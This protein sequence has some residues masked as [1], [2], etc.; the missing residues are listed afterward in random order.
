V[1]LS[2]GHLSLRLKLVLALVAV[3]A[4][5][6]AVTGGES[7][8]RARSALEAAAINQLTAIRDERRRAVEAYFA[9][10]RLE[11]VTL[12]ETHLVAEAMRRFASAWDA[13][14][15]EASRLPPPVVAAYRARVEAFYQQRLAPHLHDL[16]G[17]P[18]V[19]VESLM[20]A[21]PAALVLQLLYVVA[22]PARGSGDAERRDAARRAGPYE[23]AYAAL[24]PL[25]RRLLQRH[26]YYDIYL[27]EHRTGRI[28]F[29]VEREADIG[30]S[31]LTG[32]Y[33]TTNLARAFLAA[34]E[35]P[36]PSAV[37]LADFELYVPSRGEPNAFMAAP[38]MAGGERIGV[39]AVEL[40]AGPVDALMTGGQSW[41]RG[42]LGQ[43]GETYLVGADHRMRSNSRFLVEDPDAYLRLLAGLGVSERQRGLIRSHRSTI[44]FE[45]VSS[46]AVEAALAGGS[47]AAITRD[48]RGVE[49]IS[50]HAPV[51]VP[52]V[53]WGLIAKIDTAEALAPA[54]ALRNTVAI[55]GVIIALIVGGLALLLG[56]SLTRPLG[57]LMD[58]MRRLGK[59]SL[60]HRVPVDR[61]DEVGRIAAA[62]NQMADDLQET[63]VS[64]D[65]V[66][67]ILTSMTDAVIVVRPAPGAGDDWRDAVV[68][69][70]NP[71]ACALIGRPEP[72]IVG[73]RIRDLIPEIATPGEGG[74]RAALWLEE[75]V[76]TGS[77]GGREVVYRI[78]DGREVPVL[79]SSALMREERA[80]RGGVVWAAQD[81]T[82]MKK[83]EARNTF[84]RETFGR[85]VSDEV[86][87]TLL[88]A[89]E[90]LRLG[91]E[92]RTVTIVMSD[93]RGFTG[94]AERLTPE[95]VV[96]FLNAY[97][98]RM[99]EPILRYRGTIS[100]IMGDGILM[101]FGA[102]MSAE[103]D[104]E[105]AVTCALEMQLAMGHFGEERRARGLPTVEMGIGL[106]T[107]R[108]VVG[109][110][111]S[112]RR[113]K[114]AAV[115][116]AVNLAARIESYTTG[117][118][119]LVSEDTFRAVRAPL[120]VNGRL[121]IEPKG[122]REALTVYDIVG[123]GGR[124][125]L[126]IAPGGEDL[127]ALTAA[128]PVR[129][130]VLEEKH[131]G[132]TVLEG[133]IVR[134]SRR[135]AEIATPTPAEP[136]SNVKV[137]LLDAGGEP[138]PG[139]LY[140]KVVDGNA[141]SGGFRVRFTSVTPELSA[142]IE[143]AL[144]R[145]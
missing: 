20:P 82:E 16:E 92:T 111:G 9:R 5:A 15:R 117:G 22:D 68:V 4:L 126:R 40:P 38:I 94:L 142:E 116:T 50:A 102:P 80:G 122:A 1:R 42:G 84:I 56:R 33:R 107:G 85:Y 25:L 64:R 21:D 73:E 12:A 2:L 95:D 99:V 37:A 67:N 24:E 31:L 132:R 66:G 19:T 130:A 97:F 41:R 139:D 23:E 108:V 65:Y 110:I 96:S 134:L 11:T 14:E 72:A 69:T 119:I 6:V 34:R 103:D 58:G 145:Q 124:L 105:R 123:I 32:P 75:V 54:V 39:L 81:L 101:L 133:R 83:L 98:E 13:L 51:A 43:T 53:R 3:G 29:S 52:G 100:E 129:F 118:Q 44:L 61:R 106:H 135:G 63:T 109:N 93:L 18:P 10:I 120:Q 90:A 140:A 112:E 26:G 49:V 131:V 136:L 30:T 60:G 59:G 17:Q 78:V 137:W 121:R 55:S 71:S 76:R 86:V 36:D 62:F 144:S 125:D 89:P 70:V 8:R 46:P 48:Y 87:T 88:S 114:Y 115:G 91:G 128:I 141:G 35:A 79:F 104:A 138:R 47:G 127:T 28:V 143:A 57:R 27:I 45:R 74:R 113:T 77:I 7:Y